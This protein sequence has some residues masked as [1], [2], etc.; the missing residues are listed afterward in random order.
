MFTLPVIEITSFS[1]RLGYNKCKRTGK[2]EIKMIGGGDIGT[3]N[4]MAMMSSLAGLPQKGEQKKT[5]R[6]EAPEE[7]QMTFGENF[8]EELQSSRESA[9]TRQNNTRNEVRQQ[10]GSV[11]RRLLSENGRKDRKAEVK[12]EQ[13]VS[14]E[15]MGG[16]RLREKGEAL[17]DTTAQIHHQFMKQRASMKQQPATLS[18]PEQARVQRQNYAKNVKDMAELELKQYVKDSNPIYT[19]KGLREIIQVLGEFEDP[20]TKQ[21]KSNRE[22]EKSRLAFKNYNEGNIN[23]ASKTMRMFEEIPSD[24]GNESYDMVA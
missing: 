9:D 8:E 22:K 23:K 4:K 2:G 6:R 16:E 12:E 13:Q 17:L 3:H 24:R 11:Q 15:S 20:C 21:S 10:A 7:S 14:E 19:R 1:A 5:N 18:K